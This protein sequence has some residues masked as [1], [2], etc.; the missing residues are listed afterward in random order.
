LASFVEQFEEYK[1]LWDFLKAFSK[2]NLLKFY[3]ENSYFNSSLL[4]ESSSINIV[5]KDFKARPKLSIESGTVKRCSGS[6]V[7][8]Y[9]ND[10]TNIEKITQSGRSESSDSIPI[11]FNNLISNR[12]EVGE[13]SVVVGAV[14]SFID[15]FNNFKMN[16]SY[17]TNKRFLIRH[18]KPSFLKI[19]Y[20]DNPTLL[21]QE[22]PISSHWNSNI[23]LGDGNDSDTINN[24][25]NEYTYELLRPPIPNSVVGGSQ[26]AYDVVIRTIR[27]TQSFGS[28]GATISRAVTKLF[29]SNTYLISEVSDLKIKSW[30][31]LDDYFIDIISGNELSLNFDF[32]LISPP[33]D[34]NFLN[35]IKSKIY[36]NKLSID[37]TCNF[38]SN[39]DS[40]IFILNG[41][42]SSI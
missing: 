3:T 38:K 19:Y 21:S 22:M 30:E 27:D 7:E 2:Q 29:N 24:M 28:V 41:F 39:E 9:D 20:F 25:G 18:F 10:L 26:F 16:V 34:S 14:G 6:N 4:L 13:N 31:N 11:I 23:L 40:E 15:Y 36:I 8:T 5:A 17:T 1:T 35:T 42:T 12:N 33:N 32:D 37:L